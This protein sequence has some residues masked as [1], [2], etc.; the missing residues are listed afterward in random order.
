MTSYDANA[1]VHRTFD[2]W[3]K[4]DGKCVYVGIP[5]G[6]FDI[7]LIFF[8]TYMSNQTGQYFI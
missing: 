2:L 3:E 6:L 5:E 4:H 8:A 7:F 1:Q